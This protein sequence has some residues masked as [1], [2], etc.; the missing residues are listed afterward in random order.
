M[1][2]DNGFKNLDELIGAISIFEDSPLGVAVTERWRGSLDRE[3]IW[4]NEANSAYSGRSIAELLRVGDM[5]L[6]QARLHGPEES[7]SLQSMVEKG[8]PYGGRYFWITADGIH[9]AMCYKST[10]VEIRGRL[11]LV[12]TDV[13]VK[14]DKE[15][16]EFPGL[17]LNR[18]LDG[19][20]LN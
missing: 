12:G 19:D 20:F 4:C 1:L 5:R 2:D 16:Q 17:Q 10:P 7:R 3:L 11:F 15:K 13:P 9:L 18:E 8:R 14:R 6:L